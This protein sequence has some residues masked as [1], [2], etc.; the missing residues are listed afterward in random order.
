METNLLLLWIS[1]GYRGRI[2]VYPHSVTLVLR[3]LRMYLARGSG[4]SGEV[5]GSWVKRP[6][7]IAQTSTLFLADARRDLCRLA[8]CNEQK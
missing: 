3:W 8:N 1:S 4:V 5:V 6:V 7:T 2:D